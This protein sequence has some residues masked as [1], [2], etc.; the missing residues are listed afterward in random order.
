MT[1]NWQNR[2]HQ[3]DKHSNYGHHQAVGVCQRPPPAGSNN[4]EVISGQCLTSADH[5][6]TLAAARH[7]SSRPAMPYWLPACTVV[8]RSYLPGRSPLSSPTITDRRDVSQDSAASSVPGNKTA[9]V[10]AEKFTQPILNATRLF[11]TYNA[12]SVLRGRPFNVS[13]LSAGRQKGHPARKKSSGGPR[14]FFRVI[15]PTW[16]NARK[17]IQN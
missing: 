5:R 9:P 10:H 11:S 13:I 7:G 12:A 17:E 1:G 14:W 8:A 15:R 4:W 3:A 16:S 2:L 6:Q